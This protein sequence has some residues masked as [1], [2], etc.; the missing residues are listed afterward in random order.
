MLEQFLDL[1]LK[2][3]GF[4]EATECCAGLVIGYAWNTQFEQAGRIGQKQVELAL[5]SQ[6]TYALRHVYSLMAIL[7]GVRAQRAATE[8]MLAMARS[9]VERLENPE[10]RAFLEFV[11][12]GLL[13]MWGDYPAAETLLASAIHRLREA[14]PDAV[15]WY[16]GYVGIC[17]LYSSS[18]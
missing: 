3:D 10:P 15:G 16:L 5:S 9:T 17:L 13:F 4:G 2:S 14:S 8:H 12:G 18:T 7:H 1:A 11:H 6:D